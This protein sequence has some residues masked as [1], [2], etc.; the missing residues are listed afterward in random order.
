MLGYDSLAEADA[1]YHRNYEPG[2]NGRA[3]IS[4]MPIGMFKEWLAN[5]DTKSP[6]AKVDSPTPTAVRAVKPRIER[7]ALGARAAAKRT[8][9]AGE[10]APAAP[11]IEAPAV[12]SPTPKRDHRS[13]LA[14]QLSDL[15]EKEKRLR[16]EN[17]RRA[18][19]STFRASTARMTGGPARCSDRARRNQ[20]R[21]GKTVAGRASDRSAGC[22]AQDR[23]GSDRCSGGETGGSTIAQTEKEARA[24]RAAKPAVSPAPK[25]EKEARARAVPPRPEADRE[26]PTAKSLIE[27][28]AER[29]LSEAQTVDQTPRD[30]NGNV[31]RRAKLSEGERYAYSAPTETS[32][33]APKGIDA[34]K[35]KVVDY[36]NGDATRA[37]VMQTL[38]D[39]KLPYG[40]KA[41]IT[42][43]MQGDG[44]SIG[45][46]EAM[47]SGTWKPAAILPPPK[48]KREAKARK[49]EK[50]NGNPEEASQSR[51][52]DVEA[53]KR[54]R[55]RACRK[56][57]SGRHPRR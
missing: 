19:R 28:L 4:E 36:M 20:R 57:D 38:N 35:R 37:E 55:P 56:R 3:A 23:K 54:D 32:P 51:T 33:N 13:T 26:Q 29:R 11:E 39:S 16:K 52:S 42:Q 7:E 49:L 47:D 6:F 8:G 17:R 30:A 48:T 9:I 15:D 12:N 31:E 24:V 40:V 34:A 46:L 41:S 2:W 22:E 5:G 14:E 27:E 1:A 53:Q 21:I 45:E 10:N 44:P 50:A 18:R 25:T 43:R